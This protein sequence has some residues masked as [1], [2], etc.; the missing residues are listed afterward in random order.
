[1]KDETYQGWTNWH[2]WNANL[3][4]NNEPES[5]K[6]CMELVKYSKDH[7]P[8]ETFWRQEWEN[9]DG[10]NTDKINFEEI[11]EAFKRIKS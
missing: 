2:T 9:T 6:Y 10:I 7:L 1:M 8:L 11:F 5:H 4:L 3:W